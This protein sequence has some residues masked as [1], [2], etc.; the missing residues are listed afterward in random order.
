MSQQRSHVLEE[1]HGGIDL[2]ELEQRAQD[3]RRVLD[4]SSNILSVQHPLSVRRAVQMACIS[5]YPD[6]ECTALRER[7][8]KQ[9]GV[10]ARSIVL[11]NGCCELI[12][13]LAQA[14]LEPGQR[15]LVL[16]PTFS[17]YRRASRLA[18]AEIEACFME[19]GDRSSSWVSALGA[20][21]D[22]HPIELVWIC[23][24]NNPCGTSRDRKEIE[25]LARDNPSTVFAVDESYIEFAKATESIMG[26]TLPN[27]VCLRS[28]TK[29]RALAGLRL[30]YVVASER[31]LHSLRCHRPPWSV[32]A[33]AQDVGVAVMDAQWHYE[34]VVTAT[35]ANR[36]RLLTELRQRGLKPL[37]SDANF[38]LVPVGKPFENAAQ[39]RNRLLQDG[40]LVRD[41]SSFGLPHHVRI[42]IG[43]DVAIDRLLSA[44]DAC[45][46]GSPVIGRSAEIPDRTP[47]W[48]A[49]FRA[50][51]HELFRMRRDVRR[52]RSDAIPRG[53]VE[54]WIDAACMAPSVG[55]SQP[56]R[57]VSVRDEGIRGKIASEFEK[58]NALAAT[59][60][61][62]AERAHYLRLKLAGIQEAPEQLA[63][64]VEADPEKGRGL[65]RRTMPET[66]EYSVVAAIQNF[67]LA[68]RA[69]GVGVGWVSILNVDHVNEILGMPDRYQLIAYLCIGYPWDSNNETPTLEKEGWELRSAREDVWITR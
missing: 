16:E 2:E 34:E 28:L 1:Y 63:V 23:N 48:G 54:R 26:S 27:L 29:S 47:A 51:L 41:C 20:S 17:E 57:F 55:L 21:L 9:H 59:G 31:I 49:E 3:P 53:S 25:E 45:P 58:Q 11:G 13:L 22:Q 15:T 19:P 62:H 37:E 30:G 10:D 69:E 52:F 8:A 56:W 32:N 7:L 64:Y 67:W 4:L 60:Y 40:V 18:G 14:L 6:R 35:L 24:P 39:F 66:V 36:N 65:G 5:S 50:Q 12:Q 46:S 33:I 61:E 38:L 42:A 44:I 43:D 68:A